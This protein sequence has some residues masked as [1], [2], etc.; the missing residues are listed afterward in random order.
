MTKLSDLQRTLLRDAVQSDGAI[1]TPED[2]SPSV[3][4]LIKRGYFISVP[5]QGG[6]STLMITDTGRAAIAGDADLDATKPPADG[7]EDR[8]SPSPAPAIRGKVGILV[9]LLSRPQ[10]ATL[11]AMMAETGWQAHSVR[12]AISGAI[13]RGLGL[14]VLSEKID[15]ARRYRIE[16]EA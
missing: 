14:Y 10:G 9:Q 1:T 12:G 2:H 16:V 5:Q 4:G 15:G 8:P 11:E 6:P 13:K 7:H 3:A